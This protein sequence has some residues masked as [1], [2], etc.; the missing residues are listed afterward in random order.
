[1]SAADGPTATVVFRVASD[2]GVVNVETLWAFELG[3]ARYRLDNIPYYAYSV[4]LGDVVL[5][6][7]DP[8]DQR[9]T[10]AS[11]LEKSGNRTVRV[12]FDAPAEPGS[13]AEQLL[14]RLV[15]MGCDYEDANRRY[16]AI[17][18][19]PAV[20]L[21]AVR[22]VLVDNA[23]TWEHADPSYSELYPDDT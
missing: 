3:G 16:V 10:F 15:A 19:P 7:L 12:L 1:M 5:A 13:E 18:I 17:N 22:D 23:L 14:G 21:A 9:P 11:V 8:Q 6:P 20:E 4:S 2:T